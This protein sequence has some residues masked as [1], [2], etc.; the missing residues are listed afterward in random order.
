MHNLE[1][2]DYSDIANEI[3][4][5]YEKSQ[6]NNKF[7]KNRETFKNSKKNLNQQKIKMSSIYHS[8]FSENSFFEKKT[9]SNSSA[10]AENRK[11][12]SSEGKSIDNKE[13]NNYKNTYKGKYKDKDINKQRKKQ[14]EIMKEKETYYNYHNDDDDDDNDNNDDDKDNSDSDDDKDNDSY[15]SLVEDFYGESLRRRD[16]EKSERTNESDN[17]NIYE[18]SSS[19]PKKYNE[20]KILMKKKI[21]Q[22]NKEFFKKNLNKPLMPLLKKQ[23]R[24]N[25]LTAQNVLRNKMKGGKPPPPKL[26]QVK[27]KQEWNSCQTDMNKYKLTKE[28]LEEKRKSLRSKNIEIARIECRNKLKQSSGK[29]KSDTVRIEDISKSERNSQ[30]NTKNE[31]E[32][33]YNVIIKKNKEMFTRGNKKQNP[34]MKNERK[35][36]QQ[37]KEVT[38]QR[39][40]EKGKRYVY[41]NE[42]EKENETESENENENESKYKYKYK[43]DIKK[44]REKGKGK[45]KDGI[46]KL[47]RNNSNVHLETVDAIT[48]NRKRLTNIQEN[49]REKPN[50]IKKREK[51]YGL[52]KE[53]DVFEDTSETVI[54]ISCSGSDF[55]EY[56]NSDR[57]EESEKEEEE[58]D[59]DIYSSEEHMYNS[60]ILQKKQ[61]V[62][63]N[64]LR[65][66][67]KRALSKLKRNNIGVD[68]QIKENPY[69]FKNEENTTY[70]EDE[71]SFSDE[72]TID[73][74]FTEHLKTFNENLSIDIDIT[75][76]KMQLD[77][78]PLKKQEFNERE[79][80]PNITQLN[81]NDFYEHSDFDNSFQYYYN[82]EQEW[83]ELFSS[84]YSAAMEK[85]GCFNEQ[86]HILKFQ[87]N[88]LETLKNIKKIIKGVKHLE[89]EKEEGE[90][91][92]MGQKK[93]T[94]EEK[95]SEK[96]KEKEKEKE[97]E[98][99]KET[100][101]KQEKVQ[102]ENERYSI[103]NRDVSNG[104]KGILEN[105]MEIR[106]LE[107]QKIFPLI[108]LL[109]KEDEDDYK[110][111]YE[112]DYKNGYENNYKNGYENDYKN[113][114]KNKMKN[115]KRTEM[116]MYEEMSH[117]KT[118]SV[119]LFDKK[120]LKFVSEIENG[121]LNRSDFETQKIETQSVS[122]K[123]IMQDNS[124]QDIESSPL[125]FSRRN[126]EFYYSS[127]NYSEAKTFPNFS[128]F[129]MIDIDKISR[130]N[131]FNEKESYTSAEISLEEEDMKYPEK[132]AKSVKNEK[133]EKKKKLDD[134]KI[135]KLDS[136]VEIQ[137][138]NDDG[139]FDFDDA[140]ANDDEYVNNN[141]DNDF[142]F[143]SKEICKIPKEYNDKYVISNWSSHE[144]IKTDNDLRA[145]SNTV[146]S[147]S[148]LMK[149]LGTSN[150]TSEK[151]SKKTSKKTSEGK[152][153]K[154]VTNNE[155]LTNESFFDGRSKE[156]M[157]HLLNEMNEHI[158]KA[159]YTKRNS[160]QDKDS[161]EGKDI[162]IDD[163]DIGIG[164]GKEKEK[165]Q[166]K[167]LKN[168]K[169]VDN[170]QNKGN[171]EEI[172]KDVKKGTNTNIVTNKKKSI[173]GISVK[174]KIVSDNRVS[175]VQDKTST[176][177]KNIEEI[178]ENTTKGKN[179]K[180]ATILNSKKYST[181]ITYRDKGNN[182][183]KKKSQVLSN[184]N[185]SN[186]KNTFSRL[187]KNE[188][189]SKKDIAS[190]KEN[191]LINKKICNTS[192]DLDDVNNLSDDDRFI[193]D[194]YLNNENEEG[195]KGKEQKNE[196]ENLS[197][198]INSQVKAFE[199]VFL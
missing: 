169:N 143:V 161:S 136:V 54:N 196:N 138:M 130:R 71:D 39:G 160:W 99:E 98:K 162:G 137:D 166:R 69:F 107:K 133:K 76:L 46:R 134:E 51:K 149:Y 182:S 45:K 168:W 170:G 33:K 131:S 120:K 175:V 82:S 41:K 171:T 124:S 125:E 173:K 34:I 12:E 101:W 178:K 47:R 67:K 20:K 199:Q 154:V 180:K 86:D 187:K 27:H 49:N 75:N 53:Q 151:T 30:W 185:N 91:N 184:N 179:E 60:I 43:Y 115:E 9:F 181:K 129:S 83:E 87:K 26:I 152:K 126:E 127:N 31:L 19:F 40:T 61:N 70:T 3:I 116:E 7:Y 55:S 109:F 15:D 11:Y 145:S 14:H 198:I 123:N 148:T 159:L 191:R 66:T 119:G 18:E 174:S 97:Q 44:E 52:N 63:K 96:E 5:N 32:N 197:E 153:K 89:E 135:Y 144:K 72:L 24:P 186:N 74:N 183:T 10:H 108:D 190:Y 42:R 177:K 100:E 189:P 36:S 28:E 85:I 158:P 38:L 65:K 88:K 139:S 103:I 29:R 35:Q 110:N 16:H 193:F 113:G 147:L 118:K 4:Q 37:I 164:E 21:V 73:N 1:E 2:S 50:R 93:E 155:R 121:I 167:I 106:D 111:E 56:E 58:T 13:K 114:Y 194:T 150:E 95:T 17:E 176:K 172:K 62:L 48:T 132:S 57:T 78:S 104:E 92:K 23:N 8:E 142:D 25:Q 79:Y 122:L 112:N 64:N 192:I 140:Y 163:I 6:I 117:M 195:Q 128:S 94:K 156:S 90:T 59:R 81:V 77:V 80:F 22:K 68:M 157:N 84:D 188:S 102:N 105:D 141:D 165:G 146:E